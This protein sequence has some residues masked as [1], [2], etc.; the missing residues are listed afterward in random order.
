MTLSFHNM[1]G[2]R[3]Y[4]ARKMAIIV[5]IILFNLTT[6]LFQLRL[7]TNI[8][9]WVQ[10]SLNEFSKGTVA[11]MT[12]VIFHFFTL[13]VRANRRQLLT[14]LTSNTPQLALSDIKAHLYYLCHLRVTQFLYQ[15]HTKNTILTVRH[16]PF[17]PLRHHGCSVNWCADLAKQTKL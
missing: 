15:I 2:R 7:V 1:P 3:E 9:Y 10:I 14:R 16:L 12:Y 8:S 6:T 4:F 17:C 5:S 11:D 13:K